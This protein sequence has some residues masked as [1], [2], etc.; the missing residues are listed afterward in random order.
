M[1]V[2][3]SDSLVDLEPAPAGPG[4]HP[5]AA[6]HRGGIRRAVPGRE[7]GAMPPFGS[8]FG[9]PV[10]VD[11]RLHGEDTITFNAGTHRDVIPHALAR[12]RAPGE[13]GIIS[14]AR[15]AGATA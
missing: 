1:A 3:A 12:F 14:F 8:L 15:R 5:P 4:S 7:L 11:S 13:P 2:L 9:L 6:G 10:Y